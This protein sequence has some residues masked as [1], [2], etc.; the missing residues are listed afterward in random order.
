M[1][2]FDA[3]AEKTLYDDE[4]VPED[5]CAEVVVCAI[6]FGSSRGEEK[7]YGNARTRSK[8]SGGVRRLQVSP[9][10]G[11]ELDAS[12]DV[13]SDAQHLCI[14]GLHEKVVKREKKW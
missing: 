5:D 6:G 13:G 4:A 11:R 2:L 14:L 12:S 10:G 3:I 7:Y 1:G 9:R 8:Y